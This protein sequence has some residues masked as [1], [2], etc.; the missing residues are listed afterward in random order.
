MTELELRFAG[1]VLTACSS[2]TQADAILRAEGFTEP[3]LRIA[4]A[5]AAGDPRPPELATAARGSGSSSDT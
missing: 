5:Y 2:S 4:R 3:D 1:E